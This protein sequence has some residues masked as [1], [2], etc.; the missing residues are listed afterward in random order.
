MSKS[1]KRKPVRYKTVQ[2]KLTAGQKKSLENYCRM[3]GTTPVKV[4][5]KSIRPLMENYKDAKPA[6]P[7]VKAKQLQLFEIEAG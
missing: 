6:F 5:K 2:L 1:K 7:V 3:R 4:I